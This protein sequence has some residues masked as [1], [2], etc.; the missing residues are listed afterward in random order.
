MRTF[1]VEMTA[2]HLGLMCPSYDTGH[3]G[4]LSV[5]SKQHKSADCCHSL[6]V[7]KAGRRDWA[8]WTPDVPKALSGMH[9]MPSTPYA[10]TIL[11]L[12]VH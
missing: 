12:W 1:Q 11:M 4:G 5:P 8:D 2:Q 3:S 9:S 10:N 6:Y 7:C